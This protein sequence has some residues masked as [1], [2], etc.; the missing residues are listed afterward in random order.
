MNNQ[1]TIVMQLNNQPT[2][3]PPTVPFYYTK[4]K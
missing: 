2:I 4:V 3:F 1:L